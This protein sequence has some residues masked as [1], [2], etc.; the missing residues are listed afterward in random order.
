MSCLHSFRGI[1]KGDA[2]GVA[3][4]LEDEPTTELY[5]LS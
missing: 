3:H 2:K 1:R 4:R 5:S